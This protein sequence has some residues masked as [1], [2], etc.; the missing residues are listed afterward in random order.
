M[1]ERP[2]LLPLS[3]LVVAL[4]FLLL[5]PLALGTDRLLAGGLAT[6]V[7]IVVATLQTLHPRR[8]AV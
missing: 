4:L 7:L 2:P 5:A 1:A 6:L 3:H 8:L